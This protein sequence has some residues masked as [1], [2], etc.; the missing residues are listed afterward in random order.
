ML[1]NLKLTGWVMTS[2]YH[3]SLHKLLCR[4]WNSLDNYLAS[5]KRDSTKINRM[6]SSKAISFAFLCPI[7]Y[8]ILPFVP[9]EVNFKIKECMLHDTALGFWMSLELKSE[10]QW[11]FSLTSALA[12]HVTSMWMLHSHQGEL[13]RKCDIVDRAR[14]AE[15]TWIHQLSSVWAAL[16]LWALHLA[17]HTRAVQML[18]LFHIFF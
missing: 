14:V 4:I 9:T 18:L 11:E 1:G 8:F 5:W 15:W 6:C 2:A 13:K 17:A 12:K 10:R 3:L 7:P 16:P